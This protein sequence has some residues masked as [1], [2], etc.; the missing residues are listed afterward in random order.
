MAIFWNPE[1]AI[2]IAKASW[3]L[4]DGSWIPRFIFKLLPNIFKI[5][6]KLPPNLSKVT[7]KLPNKLIPKCTKVTPK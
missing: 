1:L 6:S 4:V 5:D 7:P 3:D 2:A